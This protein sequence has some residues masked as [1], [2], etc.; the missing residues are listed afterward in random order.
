[1]E[2]NFAKFVQ[3]SNFI[4]AKNNFQL[5]SEG[6]SAITYTP[7]STTLTHVLLHIQ[8]HLLKCPLL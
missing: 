2:S 1:M 8:C 3:V 7:P 4:I 6:F 5:N